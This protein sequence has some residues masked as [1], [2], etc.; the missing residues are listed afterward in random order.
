M[1]TAPTLVLASRRRRGKTPWVY[2]LA[3]SVWLVAG[4]GAGYGLR[5]GTS[6]PS[7][8]TFQAPDG[9]PVPQK[10]FPGAEISH[11]GAGTWR[12]P[13]QAPLGTYLVT[14]TDTSMGC[15]WKRL[16]VN[17]GKPKSEIASGTVTRGE[18]NEVTLEEGDHWLVL[19]GHCSW[20]RR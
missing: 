11:F 5:A 3:A 16:K 19:G 13:A 12:V 14:A 18:L 8:A 1:S 6:H 15:I 4:I 2:I 10:D 7:A 9:A 17:D 20:I